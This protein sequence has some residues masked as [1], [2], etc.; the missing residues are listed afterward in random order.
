MGAQRQ[1]LHPILLIFPYLNYTVQPGGVGNYQVKDISMTGD[2]STHWFRWESNQIGFRSIHGHYSSLPSSDYLMDQ[3]SYTGSGV[4]PK[5]NEKFRIN[6]WL[7][8][9]YPP[10]DSQEVEFIIDRFEFVP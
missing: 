6:L 5:G 8:N 2:L 7:F 9:G 4:P 3:W 1:I 10:S